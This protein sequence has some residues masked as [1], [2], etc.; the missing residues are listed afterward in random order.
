MFGYLTART[1][2]LD[3]DRIKR[4]KACYCGLCRSLRSRHGLSAGLTLNFDMTFL[5]LLLSSLYEPK[6]KSGHDPC[7]VHPLRPRS[8]FSDE[9]TDYAADMNLALGYLLS[10]IHI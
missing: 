9:F 1:D 5:V 4:Y 10:L 3:E 8:W 7:L 6:E 2:L